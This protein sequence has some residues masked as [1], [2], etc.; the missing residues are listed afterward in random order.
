[1]AEDT[2][3]EHIAVSDEVERLIQR[4]QELRNEIESIWAGQSK[5][6]YELVSVFIHRGAL[7]LV[8][9]HEKITLTLD[10]V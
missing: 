3:A 5:A 9:I 2:V 7:A 4:I 10:M 6:T 1:M 8:C